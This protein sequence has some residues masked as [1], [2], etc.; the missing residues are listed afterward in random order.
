MSHWVWREWLHKG[1]S[2]PCFAVP[3]GS[4]VNPA[5]KDTAKEQSL[6]QGRY[7]RGQWVEKVLLNHEAVR[8]V[9]F[10]RSLK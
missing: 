10:V 1:V 4:R 5:P 2:F 3:P 8:F 9:A 6:Q 7:A